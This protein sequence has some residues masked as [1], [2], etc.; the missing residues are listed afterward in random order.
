MKKH[1]EIGYEMMRPLGNV[2]EGLLEGIRHHHE[3][4]DGKGY[5]DGL[6]DTDIP[7]VA[8]IL[9]LADSYDA[10]TSNRVYRFRLSDD[11][12]REELKQCSGAQ[13]DP[14]LTEIFLRLMDRKEIYPMTV[15]GQATDTDGNIRNSAM[16]ERRL[17]DDLSYKE[18]I[19]SPTHVRMLCYLMKLMERK[20]KDF[21][22]IFVEKKHDDDKFKEKLR[23][24]ISP[25]DVGID[26]TD[27]WYLLALY[28]KTQQE[29]EAF[30]K[31]LNSEF[32]GITI[33]KLS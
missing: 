20:G 26:Y 6:S 8:R 33:E 30:E 22:V 23:K 18:S 27:D 7:L 19:I 32:G 2:I 17:A 13:F 4:F 21:Y 10:M 28:D 3:R 1:V 25:H 5:P 24:Y 31:E 11:Q 12:V 14:A 16:L 29:T 9:A 15:E